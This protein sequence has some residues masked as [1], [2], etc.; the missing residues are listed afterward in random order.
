M[1]FNGVI[2][3]ETNESRVQKIGANIKRLREIFHVSQEDVGLAI[4]IAQRDV[5]KIEAGKLSLKAELIYPL[6]D[7]FWVS[8]DQLLGIE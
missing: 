3:G 7:Y 1:S 4:G 5:S 8:A 2:N 6:C